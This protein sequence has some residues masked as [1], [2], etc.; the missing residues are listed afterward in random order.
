MGKKCLEKGKNPQKA[1]QH[2]TIL[3]RSPKLKMYTKKYN[4]VSPKL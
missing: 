2:S 4:K 3:G 1:P